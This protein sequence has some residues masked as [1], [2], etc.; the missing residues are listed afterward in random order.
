MSVISTVY[1]GDFNKEKLSSLIKCINGIEVLQCS[2]DNDSKSLEEMLVDSAK[3]ISTFASAG[4]CTLYEL[5]DDGEFVVVASLKN[6]PGSKLIEEEKNIAETVVKNKMAKL[7]EGSLFYPLFNS[8][9][10]PFFI[11]VLANKNGGN[12]N[13]NDLK[14]NGIAVKFISSTLYLLKQQE[15]MRL[16]AMLKDNMVTTVI[17]D[18][19]DPVN[20]LKE[21]LAQVDDLPK[22]VG[23]DLDTL[24]NRV[25][26]SL[27]INKMQDGKITLNHDSIN[28]KSAINATV[29]SLTK[30]IENYKVDITVDEINPEQSFTGDRDLMLRVFENHLTNAIKHSSEENGGLGKIRIS[31]ETNS[32]DAIVTFYDTGEGIPDNFKTF[33]FKEFTQIKSIG[34]SSGIGL[35]FCKLIVEAHGGKIEVE[36]NEPQGSVFRVI[37]PLV[38]TVQGSSKNKSNKKTRIDF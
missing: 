22:S 8:S 19:E 31:A 15:N 29:K 10:T 23:Y 35:T 11:A 24:Y 5:H 26:N 7:S 34:G 9:G 3:A 32:F 36:D 13:E 38:P 30:Y 25:Y 12:F 17:S 28:L 27:E 20:K 6:K 37:S 21:G 14:R 16:D 4:D 1:G 2:L 33:I 18:L